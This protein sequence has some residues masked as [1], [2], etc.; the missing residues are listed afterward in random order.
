M[1][2][3]WLVAPQR[4]EHPDGDVAESPPRPEDIRVHRV[5]GQTM[6][7][8]R[9]IASFFANY[10]NFTGRACRSEYWFATLFVILVSI[11][12]SLVDR[13][14]GHQVLQGIF[15]LAVFLPNLAIHVRRLHDTDRSGLWLVG[16]Y[17]PG[18]I[19]VGAGASMMV[20][21]TVS[22][23]A[24]KAGVAPGMTVFT[25]GIVSGIASY[26]LLLVWMCMR[27]T[28]G[29]NRFGGDPLDDGVQGY[30]PRPRR[31]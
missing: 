14:V 22:G 27:G 12:C 8:G 18:F 13:A 26:V 28:F 16:V 5:C 17:V 4:G 11:A 25:L 23:Q 3:P 10:A 2:Q 30:V 7:F 9:A 24:T 6:S 1:I 15:G 20:A 19:L 21:A 29:P 31:A